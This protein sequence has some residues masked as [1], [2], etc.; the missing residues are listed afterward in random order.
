MRLAVTGSIATDHLMTFPGR[1]AD[2]LVAE[3]LDKVSLS[4]LVEELDIRRG[5]V[6]ANIAF[7]LGCLGLRPLLVAAVGADFA[8]YRSWLERHGV[9]TESVHV[10]DVRHTA[11]FICTT[12][13]EAN[14]IAS[15]YP[16][17]M[18]EARDIEL[19][20]V[21]ERV[22]GLD[23]VL[24][25]P[26]DPEAMLRHTEESRF[27]GFPFAADPSQ[28]LARMEGPEIRQLI[29]GAA[30]LFTNEYEAA[31][32]QRKTGW[33]PADIL[34]KVGV[35]VTTLGAK[36]SMVESKG[37]P[38]VVVGCPE[39]ERK[40]DPTGVGDGFRAGYLAGLAWG[41]PAERC[42]QIGSLMATYVIETIGTQEYDLA[43]RHFLERIAK[44]YGDD[45]A[46]DVQPHLACF[47]P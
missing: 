44:A 45:A 33:G 41:L 29:E 25:G 1:F 13:S 5:G 28:Q 37:E 8:D 47:R 27:R 11:R 39:E 32:I 19:Q 16:G 31:L 17:A 3:Q 24:V 43:Q 38:A 18:S 4:F 42:C 20:P 9:D 35:R 30:Y 2:S 46:A 21:A 26:N 40:A 36:G 22:G 12:D 7:G 6:A 23:L 15:F 34:D 10:S 14:Q